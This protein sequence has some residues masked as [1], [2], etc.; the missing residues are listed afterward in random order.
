MTCPTKLNARKSKTV[1]P[2]M[3]QEVLTSCKGASTIFQVYFGSDIFA[4]KT[5]KV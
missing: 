2:L 5:M 1:L 3:S 4:K